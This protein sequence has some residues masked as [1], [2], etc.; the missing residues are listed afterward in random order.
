ML[1]E[2]PLSFGELVS[3]RWLDLKGNPLELEL[4]KAAGDCQDEKGCKQAAQ[5][6]V[7]LMRDRAAK[8]QRLRDKQKIVTKRA[9]SSLLFRMFFL[10][11][12]Y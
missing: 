6:V 11:C 2:L 3:L 10:F 12:Y 9:F 7:R 8:Q 1:Q 5:N 4:G